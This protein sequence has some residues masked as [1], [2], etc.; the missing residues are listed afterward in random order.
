MLKKYIAIIVLFQ[1][2]GASYLICMHKFMIEWSTTVEDAQQ[3]D[4]DRYLDKEIKNYL[5]VFN[6]IE[7]IT[8]LQIGHQIVKCHMMFDM[9]MDD[10]LVLCPERVCRLH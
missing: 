6:I 4:V 7:Y 1:E 3:Q 5:I 10:F 2:Y 9:K 8:Q